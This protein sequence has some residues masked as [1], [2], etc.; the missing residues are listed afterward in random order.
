MLWDCVMTEEWKQEFDRAQAETV[1]LLDE[2]EKLGYAYKRVAGV[3]FVECEHPTWKGTSEE[4]GEVTLDPDKH[5]PRWIAHA[6]GRGFHECLRRDHPDWWLSKESESETVAETI[7]FFVEARM[8][9]H[10]KRRW[11]PPSG[12]HSKVLDAC[13]YKLGGVPGFMVL[14]QQCASIELLARWKADNT[15][16]RLS[17]E[18]GAI[19]REQDRREIEEIRQRLGRRVVVVFRKGGRIKEERTFD[20]D[21]DSVDEVRAIQYTILLTTGD[22]PIGPKLIGRGFKG[23]LPW[24][25]ERVREGQSLTAAERFS[26]SCPVRIADVMENAQT[27]IAT[28]YLESS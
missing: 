2:C 13:D 6:M 15:E 24:E 16:L 7:R 18:R 3:R 26:F 27:G 12:K 19:E 25:L 22:T 14:L 8:N 21:S 5:D 20:S 4:E 28:I 10:T 11:K 17:P 1:R 23:V 9:R